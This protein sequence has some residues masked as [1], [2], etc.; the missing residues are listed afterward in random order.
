MR[1]PHRCRRRYDSLVGIFAATHLLQAAL[2]H[3]TKRISYQISSEV[4]A[5]RLK[6]DIGIIGPKPSDDEIAA[7]ERCIR[8]VPPRDSSNPSH[9]P[10]LPSSWPFHF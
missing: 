10:H 5:E 1:I 2:K 6:F 7:V 9:L 8:F 3:V 4:T